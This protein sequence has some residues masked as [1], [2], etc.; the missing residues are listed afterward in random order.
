MEV[1]AAYSKNE[2]LLMKSSSGALFGVIAKLFL[3][4]GDLVFGAAF[5]DNFNLKHIGISDEQELYKLLGSKYVQ[6]KL[7]ETYRTI[8]KLLHN[9][10]KRILFVGTPCQ[11]AGLK[12]FLG[13]NH[14]NLFT[15]DIICHGVPSQKMFKR[16]NL[17]KILLNLIFVAKRNLV[18][19]CLVKCNYPRKKK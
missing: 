11:V 3:K 7:G 15:I 17:K 4:N 9:D 14:D 16:K 19:G 13:R 5:D 8:R 2:N 18:G 1:Y 12:S 10:N 6:S